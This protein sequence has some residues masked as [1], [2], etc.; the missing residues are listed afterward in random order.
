MSLRA[1]IAG[2]AQRVKERDCRAVARIISAL[3]NDPEFAPQFIPALSPFWTKRPRL[4]ITGSPGVGKST[5]IN[6]LVKLLRARGQRVGVVAVDPTSPFSGGA[7]LGDRVRMQGVQ[8][9]E[10]V[11]I[12]SMGSRGSLGGLSVATASVVRVL[13]SFGSDFILVETVGMGQTGFDIAD[14][15]DTV[16]LLLSPESGDGVQT[17]K[18]GVMEIA[19]MYVVNKADRPGAEGL[20]IEIESL[21]GMIEDRLRWKPPVF[22]A[23]ALEGEGMERILEVFAEHQNFLREHEQYEQRRLRQVTSEIRFIVESQIRRRSFASP[24]FRQRIDDLAGKVMAA[25]MDAYTAAAIIM[26]E[27]PERLGEGQSQ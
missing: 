18:A 6:G 23:K 9:D 3:E 1:D 4:G 12:R 11:F 5:V 19:D 14:I 22:A 15:A 26:K 8:N 16:A 2:L 13:E 27:L 17:M 24:D 7:I 20:M 25:E 21:L 10:G